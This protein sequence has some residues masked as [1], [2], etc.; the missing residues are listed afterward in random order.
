MQDVCCEYSVEIQRNCPQLHLA[1]HCFF[2]GHL[3]V[4]LINVFVS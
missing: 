4:M 2:G 1:T 3:A